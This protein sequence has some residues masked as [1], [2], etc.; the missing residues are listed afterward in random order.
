MAVRVRFP[1][2]AHQS[3][4]QISGRAIFFEFAPNLLQ[5]F[6][7]PSAKSGRNALGTLVFRGTECGFPVKVPAV[8][9]VSQH[10]S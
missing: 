5:N 3:P 10:L 2:E 8:P 6:G 4:S 7:G 1:S 9:Y